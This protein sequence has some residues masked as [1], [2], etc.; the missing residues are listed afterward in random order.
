VACDKVQ[1]SVGVS[2][3][4]H[5]VEGVEKEEVGERHAAEVGKHKLVEVRVDHAAQQGGAGLLDD[6]LDCFLKGR[7]EYDFRVQT[8]GLR[9]VACRGLAVRAGGAEGADA[10]DAGKFCRR[11][12]EHHAGVSLYLTFLGIR[13]NYDV[14]NFDLLKLSMFMKVYYICLFDLYFLFATKIQ[15][16]FLILFL[17]FSGPKGSLPAIAPSCGTQ[18]P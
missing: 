3:R 4:E 18:R 11:C 2:C 8:V 9:V 5:H 7:V 1:W 17:N 13:N 15:Y 12:L 14:E 10:P 16:P 6:Q